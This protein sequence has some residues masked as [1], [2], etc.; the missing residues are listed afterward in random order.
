VALPLSVI[1]TFALMQAMGFTLNIV[2]LLSLS[3]VVGVLVDDAIVEVENIERHLLMGK[4][5]MQAAIDASREIGLAVVATTFTLIAVFLPTAFMSGTVGKFFVQFGWTAA[6]AVFFSLVVARMLTPMMAAWLLR[7]PASGTRREPAWMARYLAW[8]G[9]CLR[10]RGV[11]I[12]GAAILFAG[13]IGLAAILPATF[14]P[15]DDDAQSR[16]TLSMSPGTELRATIAMAERA[17]VVL[18][19]HPH[20]R[21]VFTAIGGGSDGDGGPSDPSAALVADV[22]T[23]QL[24]LTLTPRPERDGLRKQEI[25]RELRALL[26]GLPGVR[27]QVGAGGA[28]IYTLVL[29]GEDGAMLARHAPLVERDLRTLDG[30]GA[31]MS[32]ASLLRPELVVTPD[33]ARAADL[34]VTSSGIAETL[35]IAT[36]GDYPENLPKLNLEQRQVPVVVRLGEAARADLDTLSACRCRARAVRWR[37]KTS[38]RWNTAAGRSR[39]RAWTAGARSVSTS[40]ST[41]SPWATSNGRSW[42]CPACAG[43]LPGSSAA[44]WATPKRWASWPPASAWRC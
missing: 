35:R 37:W 17:R 15:A 16:V 34:G 42:R 1:P 5:P 31:V 23:A 7:A 14:I 3:L 41:A 39:S 29:S 44:R 36:V 24:T 8:A 22:R 2:T 20:V 13:G 21:Q 43:C 4:E 40:S 26:A 11:T 27:I 25:E 9:W 30:I 12:G 6:G 38:P 10:H 28:E 33:F 19:Q 32:S 18:A